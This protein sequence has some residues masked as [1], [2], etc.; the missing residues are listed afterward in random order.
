VANSYL[1]I[2]IYIYLMGTNNHKCSLTGVV[3][4]PHSVVVIVEVASAAVVVV[5]KDNFC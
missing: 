2:N 5:G 1:Y 4:S 3:L